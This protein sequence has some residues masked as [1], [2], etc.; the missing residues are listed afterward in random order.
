MTEGSDSVRKAYDTVAERYALEIAGELEHKVLDRC[1][2]DAF[3]E[4]IRSADAPGQSGPTAGAA[5]VADVGCG[6]GH[7]TQYLADR[8]LQMVGVDLSPK[9]VEV[10]RARQPGLNFM[11]GSLL[12]P[13]V[14]DGGWAGAVALYSMIHLPPADRPL[15][16][17]ALARAIRS[18]GWLLVAFHVSDEEHEPGALKHLDALWDLPIDLDAYFIDPDQMCASLTAAGFSV[19]ARIE[20]EPL[21]EVEYASRR[22][23]LLLQRAQA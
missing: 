11:V 20:R 7:V 12:A 2:L 17:A 14:P 15:A 6:P 4:L 16:A 23:L 21:P 22:C 8:G 1:V 10:A 9:M 13:P 19:R 18:G 5:P 3:A